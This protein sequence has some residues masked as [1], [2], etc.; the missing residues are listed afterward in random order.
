MS[1]A[2]SL[3]ET[4]VF[5]TVGVV[6]LVGEALGPCQASRIEEE[7]GQV[8][9]EMFF[10]FCRIMVHVMILAV[11][12]SMAECW[13]NPSFFSGSWVVA[14]TLLYIVYN[15][16]SFGKCP[17]T[18][19]RLN[20]FCILL[21]GIIAAAIASSGFANREDHMGC[22]GMGVASQLLL[23]LL[24]PPSW[25]MLVASVIYS[26]A[27]V[28]STAMAHGPLA[29]NR[30]F[31]LQQICQFG[32]SIAIPAF[33]NWTLE[34]RISAAFKSKDAD[35][36]SFGFRQVLRGICDGDLLLDSNFEIC[37]NAT[38]LQRLLG[39][40]E[41]FAGRL[42]HDLIDGADARKKFHKFVASSDIP[43]REACYDGGEA[44]PHC[45]RVPLKAPSG[46]IVKVDVFHVSLP[47]LY[48]EESHHLLS[49]K[50]DPDSMV[51][52]EATP[53]GT[54]ADR[55]LK[56][57]IGPPSSNPSSATSSENG[58][59]S[60]EEL[61]EMTLLLNASTELVDIEEAH[62][63]FRRQKHDDDVR[64]G[65][66]DW[67]S[68]DP[69][70]R[71]YAASAAQKVDTQVKK[72]FSISFG[73]FAEVLHAHTLKRHPSLQVDTDLVA[74]AFVC[75]SLPVNL[76]SS[77][78]AASVEEDLSPPNELLGLS[79]DDAQ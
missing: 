6:A 15:L 76:P 7:L 41:A 57:L 9:L 1:A 63:R 28:F 79:D 59:E 23:S 49:M 32:V 47:G 45:L 19:A 36:L 72:H 27:F 55:L 62:L 69:W 67:H 4:Q 8:R 21:N 56:S 14:T 24:F 5:L 22:F 26:M 70:L 34:A 2:S 48:G 51:P 33:V 38:C 64:M 52:L 12:V 75:K 17:L 65:S 10:S 60:Y 13:R 29:L 35:A 25:T 58:V 40:N 16:V 43:T 31:L 54:G 11:P 46:R 39:S 18:V 74:P 37:G 68:M 30:W 61:A 20:F 71:N 50:E 78:H 42:F 73:G 77:L 53:T 66:L 44:A 3:S